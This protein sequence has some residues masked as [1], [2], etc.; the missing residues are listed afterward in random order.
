M[1]K[2]IELDDP[3]ENL[4]AQLVKEAA[5]KTNDV[6]GD[7]TTTATLLA[8][9]IYHEGLQM[10]AA[11][12]IRWPCGA[13]FMPPSDASSRPSKRWLPVNEKDKKEI[14]QIATI[15]GNNDPSIGAVLAEAI[16]QSRQ[17][18]RDHG[19]GRQ[20]SETT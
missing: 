3:Y 18:R 4:G 12:A 13:A 10:V 9:A 20:Q 1:A 8:E 15:A 7:G 17:E 5:S 16:Y 11:G 19:R 14:A 6:A 2:E